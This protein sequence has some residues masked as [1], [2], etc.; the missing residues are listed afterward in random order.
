MP[1][2]EGGP[3]YHILLLPGRFDR[4]PFV[5]IVWPLPGSGS[6]SSPCFRVIIAHLPPPQK[7]QSENLPGFAFP[8][9][10]V[11]IKCRVIYHL[12]PHPPPL[13]PTGLGGWWCFFPPSFPNQKYHGSHSVKSQT[14]SRIQ[15]AKKT[16][17][18]F[19]LHPPLRN[20]II[21][22]PSLVLSAFYTVR[23]IFLLHLWCLPPLLP[24]LRPLRG[25]DPVL[26]CCRPFLIFLPPEYPF[27]KT[28]NVSRS[29][30][31]LAV[32][33]QNG[34]LL[35]SLIHFA[36]SSRFPFHG[37]LPPRR[38]PARLARF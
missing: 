12:G 36:Q 3:R 29:T 25:A 4:F 24:K 10:E 35:T 18:F 27:R 2:L 14:Y 28:P 30:P 17:F 20:L 8:L 1:P 32:P 15:S 26:F 34:F 31:N 19:F 37:S 16:G 33:P 6:C 7:L 38:L 13:K 23:V 9:R 11:C 5:L 21:M 22:R